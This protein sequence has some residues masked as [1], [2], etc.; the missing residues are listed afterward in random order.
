MRFLF[1]LTFLYF[2]SILDAFIIQQQSRFISNF[3][4]KAAK[5]AS[6]ES[7]MEAVKL[8]D[9]ERLQKVISRAGV[10]SRRNAEKLILDGR[11]TVNGKMISE[12]GT[13]V[14]TKIDIIAV[15]GVKL[16]L[17]DPK[18]VCWV[19]VNKPR[20]IL[21]TT[22]DD[23]DRETV[24]DI[25]PQAKELRLLP[26]GRLERDTTGVM[27]LTNE[28][29]WIHPLTHPSFIVMKK[30]QVVVS[31]IPSEKA[32]D[33]IRSDFTLQNKTPMKGIDV[34][35]MDADRRTNMCMLSVRLDDTNPASLQQAMEHIGCPIISVKRTAFG[36]VEL[37]GL[38]KGQWRELSLTE[39]QMLKES[40]KEA[41]KA[42]GSA[43]K[44][45]SAPSPYSSP[46]QYGGRS[47]Y[48][49]PVK[50]PGS[51]YFT[52]TIGRGMST[53]DYTKRVKSDAGSRSGSG[54]S[55]PPT[56]VH[57]NPFGS[58]SASRPAYDKSKSSTYARRDSPPSPSPLA[59]TDRTRTPTATGAGL[60]AVRRFTR[61]SS[62]TSTSSDDS[63]TNASTASSSRSSR[64][65]GGAV[66]DW[67]GDNEP[68]PSDKVY[69][70]RRLAR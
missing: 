43:R 10:A 48:N 57:T 6:Y 51:G 35:M 23:K 41:P 50:K 13:K 12:A 25:V 46:R 27:L 42:I 31:G 59:T 21:T 26:V 47:R 69:K 40:C 30:Y 34:E 22:S 7:N 70:T 65:R 4:L 18:K 44:T 60:S 66:R 32:L 2:I 15:D 11:V 24:M 29:G 39:I 49:R 33:E 63:S 58:T 37:K 52:R 53:G 3:D 8:E 1:S 38:R 54:T 16:K 28:N 45:Y 5:S 64:E 55:R 9:E 68:P 67:A 61:S 56:K 17:P 62:S 14:K 20:G 36:P 19:L